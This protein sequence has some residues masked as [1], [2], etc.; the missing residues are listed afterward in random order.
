MLKL[1]E[2]FRLSC[3]DGCPTVGM[4]LMPLKCTVKNGY[5]D[6][7]YIY[8]TIIKNK[9]KKNTASSNAPL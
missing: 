6:K 8:G 7:F 9:I 1:A 3:P 2:T 5:N 4:Y